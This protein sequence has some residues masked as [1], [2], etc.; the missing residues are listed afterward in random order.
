[1]AFLE[2]TQLEF[3]VMDYLK[4]PLTKVELKALIQK[5]DLPVHELIR[6]Q[7]DVYKQHF[8]GKNL[9]DDAWIDAIVAHPK[10]LKRPIVEI[11]N[12]AIWAEPAE[13]ISQLIP[14]KNDS[15]D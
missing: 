15:H 14:K 4:N 7:E 13:N 3:E 1:M 9:S 8:K 2:A 5:I 6:T 10:L 11:G 12:R